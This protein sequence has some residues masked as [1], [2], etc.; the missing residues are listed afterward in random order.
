MTKTA[1][2]TVPSSDC[3]ELL[4]SDPDT[5]GLLPSPGECSPGECP[6]EERSPGARPSGAESSGTRASGT[7]A[8]GKCWT[9]KCWSEEFIH[10]TAA[11]SYLSAGRDARASLAPADCGREAR[12]ESNCRAASCS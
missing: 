12:Y 6:A 11:P 10:S 1:I 2:T 9:A 5:Q 4:T 8:C 3:N 7:G